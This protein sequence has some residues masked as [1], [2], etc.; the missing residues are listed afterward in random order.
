MKLDRVQAKLSGSSPR[1]TPW[2]IGF[3]LSILRYDSLKQIN[4]A[5][6][7]TDTKGITPVIDQIK[8][9]IK[10]GCKMVQISMP[11]MHSDAEIREAVEE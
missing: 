9:V 3:S 2:T 5:T 10:G 8:A 1:L 6:I 11:M 4:Y 7:R